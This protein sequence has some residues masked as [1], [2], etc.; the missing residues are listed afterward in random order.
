METLYSIALTRV[1]SYQ[2]AALLQLFQQL[3]SATA[4]MEHR[5][6]IRA[7]V[8]DASPKLQEMLLT[9]DGELSRA[10]QELLF[11]QKH[12]ISVLCFNDTGYPQR[13]RECADAPLVLYY[14]GTADLNSRHVIN[15]V[16]T[17]HCTPYGQD[18]VRRFLSE[19]RLLCPDVLVVSGLAYGIDIE[20]HRQALHNG[21]P[22]VGVLAH[23]LDDIYPSRHRETAI[24]MLSQ[25]GLLT[26]FTTHT[27]ADKVNF[28]R[29]NRIVAGMADACILVESAAKGGGLITAEMAR[30]YHREVFAVPGRLGDNFSEGCNNLIRDNVAMMLTSAEAFVSV[31]GWESA[32]RLQEAQQQGIERSCFPALSIDE[33][34]IVAFLRQE[35]DLQTNALSTATGIPIGRL[36]SLL[37]QLEMK[38]VVK[39]LAGGVYH[40]LE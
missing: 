14:R 34:S 36:T 16:G 19:L 5:N 17:R 1:F 6:D 38:G 25:G 20:A 30:S 21:M 39:T 28:V 32:A 11:D 3:G 23:G 12:A 26:E 37:F 18:V 4:I 35:G 8:P 40:L 13:L 33:Q 27:N 22:T 7:A 9:V 10:E 2:P 29:R 31:M 24:Q 15:M